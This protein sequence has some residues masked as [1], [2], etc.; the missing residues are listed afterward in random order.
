M[1]GS[2]MIDEIRYIGDG[3]FIVTEEWVREHFSRSVEMSVANW[4]GVD[5]WEGWCDTDEAIGDLYPDYC[6]DYDSPQGVAEAI[7]YELMNK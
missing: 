1:E 3:K 7:I 4:L 5:N 6:K 2:A